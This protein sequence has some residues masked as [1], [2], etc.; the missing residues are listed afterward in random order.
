M[1]CIYVLK[2]S[3][4]IMIICLYYLFSMYIYIGYKILNENRTN[5]KLKKLDRTLGVSISNELDNFKYN[6]KIDVDAIN[7]IKKKSKR[8]VNARYLCENLIMRLNEEKKIIIEFV[9][10]SDILGEVL[11]SRQEQE[12][13][14]AYKIKYIGEFK[15][16]GYYDY[17]I[18]R[19][20]DNSIYIQIDSLRTLSKLG[21][22]D[23]FIKGLIKI[24][25]STSVI[26]EKVLIDSINS[27]EGNVKELNRRFERELLNNHSNNKFSEIILKYFKENRYIE[28]KDIVLK[29]LE[30]KYLDKEI[31]IACIK[32]LIDIKDENIKSELI[33]LSRSEEWE[34]RALSVVSLGS[35]CEDEDVIVVLEKALTDENWYVRQNSA[36]SLYNLIKDKEKILS[37]IYG[38]DKY[39]SD[40]ML[41][42][43]S[44]V[45]NLEK[46]LLDSSIDYDLSIKELVN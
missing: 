17:I 44:E 30:E 26:H 9:N 28:V 22:I 8:K 36:K 43:L 29:L 24:I 35:Y 7:K 32:Y 6:K 34:I 27:F 25:N 11:K 3:F 42:I 5:K 23:Y 31:K 40:A 38:K 1:G 10:K 12:Y 13:D 19:C 41:T 4:Y 20:T 18:E 45:D 21:N 15:I 14:I 16:D 39:A 46:Y 2:L 37:I 33:L